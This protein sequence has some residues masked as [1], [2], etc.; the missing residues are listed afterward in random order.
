MK[1]ISQQLEHFKRSLE[2][3]CSHPVLEQY[4][5]K[6]VIDEDKLFLFYALFEEAGISSDEKEKYV[7]TAMLV[8]TALDTHDLVSNVETGSRNLF[9]ERQLNVIAGDYY[10]GLYY[11][12]LSH[13]N[14]VKLVNTLATAIREINEQKIF[15]YNKSY[16]SV[17]EMIDSLIIVET[18]LFQRLGNHFRI[19]TWPEISKSYLAY[20]RLCEEKNKFDRG[21][22][23]SILSQYHSKRTK[24]PIDLIG[25]FI[26][27]CNHYFNEINKLL[28]KSLKYSPAIREFIMDRIRTLQITHMIA[29]EG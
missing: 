24:G 26:E 11:Y 23:S 28:D 27:C 15:L 25:S 16:Q 6:P 21:S 20:K 22:Q 7:L 10:S 29:E 2:D 14:N 19:E 5:Q 1:E 9:V 4:I 8:Q 18:A 13:M 17:D 3:Y 12:I